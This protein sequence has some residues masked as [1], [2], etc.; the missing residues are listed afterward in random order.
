MFIKKL[1]F[2]KQY[3]ITAKDDRKTYHELFNDLS[4]KYGYIILGIYRRV[5]RDP[6]ASSSDQSGSNSQAGGAGGEGHSK[7]RRN[8]PNFEFGKTQKRG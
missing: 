2:I 8:E 3:K 1:I 7:K 5:E 4:S 6:V